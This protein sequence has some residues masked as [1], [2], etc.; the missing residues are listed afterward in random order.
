MV[1]RITKKMVKYL[2]NNFDPSKDSLSSL[3]MKEKELQDKLEILKCGLT[4]ITKEELDL[5]INFLDNKFD[6]AMSK[7]F[8]LKSEANSILKTPMMYINNFL[9]TDKSIIAKQK[10]EELL[11]QADRYDRDASKYIEERDRL[12]TERYKLIEYERFLSKYEI[13]KGWRE[14]KEL[15]DES[16]QRIRNIVVKSNKEKRI[17]ATSLKSSIKRNE[18]CPYCGI[19]LNYNNKQDIHLDHI[20]PLSKGGMSTRKNLVYVC[21]SCNL[22]KSNLTLRGFIKKYSLDRDKIEMMLEELGKDF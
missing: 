7:Y 2:F 17:L 10:S 21:G 8:T 12:H 6:E 16:K 22:K 11:K 15:E 3:V 9:G 18:F 19:K 1:R 4:K 14:K 20:Y 13:M 5:K